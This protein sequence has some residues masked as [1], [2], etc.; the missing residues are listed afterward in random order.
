MIVIYHFIWFTDFMQD[1]DWQYN[2]GYSLIGMYS[3]LVG[4]SLLMIILNTVD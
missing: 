3:L 2:M 4:Y 1:P